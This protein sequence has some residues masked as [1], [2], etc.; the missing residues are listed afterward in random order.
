MVMG[1]EGKHVEDQR[2]AWQGRSDSVKVTRR[3]A[4]AGAAAVAGVAAFARSSP[5]EEVRRSAKEMNAARMDAIRQPLVV[6]TQPVP[7]PGADDAIVRVEACGICRSDWH[8][9]NGDWT[10]FGGPPIPSPTVLGHEIG[11]VVE[12]VGKDV[13][14]V[15]VGD[16]VTIPFHQ[17]CGTCSYCLDGVPNRCGSGGTPGFTHDGGWAG[18]TRVM[19]ADFNCLKLPDEID[20]VTAAALGCRFMTAYHAVTRRGA[21]S[22]G[23]W[24]VVFGCGGVGLSAVQIAAATEAL[25]IAIDINVEKLARA[26]QEGA[27]HTLNSREVEDLPT[28]IKELTNGGAHVVLD[29]LG[30]GS[31]IQAGLP[32]LR[33]GGRFVQVGL[34]SQQ[35]KGQVTIPVDLLGL[36]EWEYVGSLGN[37]QPRYAEL[38]ALVQRGRLNPRRL[39][40]RHVGLQDVTGVL[41][42]MTSFKT[43]GFNVITQF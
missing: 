5:G 14:R 40:T 4:L 9:W 25:V 31:I 18:Y 13:R 15:R 29:A 2:S 23:Q 30:L 19:F 24:V 43:I 6:T 38:F 16:R 36:N 1:E 20:S 17:S 39:V 41:E 42:D 26:S 37:P 3:E 10:W 22:P 7:E 28:A 12:E 32:S 27:M 8:V 34:T 11:G 35:D 21:V 33:R